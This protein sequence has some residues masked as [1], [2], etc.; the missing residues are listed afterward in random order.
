MLS[1]TILSTVEIN[2]M[3]E[4]KSG[5]V[6]NSIAYIVVV[7]AVGMAEIIIRTAPINGSTSNAHT[8]R[9]AISGAAIIFNTTPEII[10]C[11]LFHILTMVPSSI[12]NIS[13][14]KGLAASPTMDTVESTASGI[15][16][17]KSL[18]PI[19]IIAAY[20]VGIFITFFNARDIPLVLR[21]A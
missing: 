1:V 16:T 17:C 20:V 15:G 6:S 3:L 4:T 10:T 18:K 11:Q 14:I 21:E 5:S 19:A 7:A 12:P 2:V 8:K 9:K 13:I